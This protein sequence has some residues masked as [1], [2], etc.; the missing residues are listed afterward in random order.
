MGQD[1]VGEDRRGGVAEID[2]DHRVDA[3]GG[4]DFEGGDEGRFG[5]GV[6]I[7]GKKERATGVLRRAVIA[8]GLSDGGDV[9]I[10]ERGMEGAAAMA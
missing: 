3:I 10:V 9:V 6:G 5:Q 8:D 2:I 4:Q 1:G 7:F